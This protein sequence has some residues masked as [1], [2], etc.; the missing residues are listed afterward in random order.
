MTL[1]NLNRRIGS[2]NSLNVVP[3]TW[4]I[5]SD[6]VFASPA[7]LSVLLARGELDAALLSVSEAILRGSYDALE[8]VGVA[9]NGDVKSVILAHQVPLEQIRTV[10]CDPASLAS[11]NLLKVLL[12]ERGLRPAYRRLE[13]YAHAASST[14]VLLIG[15][16][17]LDFVRSGAPH[18]IWDLGGAWREHT[19][20]PFVFALWTLRREAAG[21]P[22]RRRLRRAH[23]QGMEALDEII[24]Q[25][26][27]YELEFRRA[28]FRR[29]LE[30]SLGPEHRRGIERFAELLERHGLGPAHPVPFVS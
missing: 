14:A 24:S 27:E 25:R 22:L 15:D 8:G 19:G 13:A 1:R 4:G 20:L 18:R 21:E 30:F 2:V 29:H 23:Q 28:Y 3:L 11:V 9:S 17:A 7:R 6:V 16:R 26:P 10:D 12:A 5:E